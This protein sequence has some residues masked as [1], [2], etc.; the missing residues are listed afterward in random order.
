MAVELPFPPRVSLGC[1]PTRVEPIRLPLRPGGA[2]VWIKRDD[3]TGADLSGNKVR[4][5]EFLLAEALERRCDVVITCGGIQSNHCRATALAAR[6]LGIDSILFLR[7]EPTASPDGNILLSRLAGAQ[8]IYIT[9]EEYARRGEVMSDEAARLAQEGRRPY[10]I[11]EGGSNALGAWGYVAML[12][13]L[14]GQGFAD[15]APHLFSAT[16]SAGTL[17]GL[18]LGVRLLSLPIRPWG[19]AVCDNELYFRGRV[20]EIAR[21]F[22]ARFGLRVDLRPE[23]IRVVE[24]YRGPGYAQTYPRLLD[25]IRRVAA[26]EAL[27]LDPVYTGK[28]FLA[29][30]DLLNDGTIPREEEVLF[31]HTG[32][33]FSL[34]AY[35]DELLPV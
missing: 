5:L 6:R 26:E 7:G 16:G 11:P 34:Y 14:A 25:L 28:A 33:I 10:V 29:M 1:F 13:E 17:A 23:E 32:G 22:Q 27:F 35:R 18:H 4:K 3:Q 2:P 8:I 15:R 12:Q 24:G 21:D 19:V 9:P 30:Q 20:M 31:L